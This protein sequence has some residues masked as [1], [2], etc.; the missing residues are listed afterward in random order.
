MHQIKEDPVLSL[1]ERECIQWISRGKSSWETGKIM[2]I[3]PN[4]V[5]F[6]LKNVKHKLDVSSRTHAAIKA[7]SLGI[8]E[9]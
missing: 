5:N 7:V 4:T 6:H 1:R 8:I 3:S 2:G 9:P